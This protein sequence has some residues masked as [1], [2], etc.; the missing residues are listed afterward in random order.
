[1]KQKILIGLVV[2][3]VIAQFFR[4]DKSHPPVNP[5]I[6]FATVTNV[7]DDINA[8]MKN[9][10]YD[11][12][13]HEVTYPWYTNIAPVSWWIKGHIRNGAKRLNF[14]E[15]GNYTN[16]QQRHQ[17]EDCVEVLNDKRMPPKSYKFLHPEA[18]LSDDDRSKIV[19]WMESLEF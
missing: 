6:D 8:M 7:P 17:I 14:S 19:G 15:W 10:C 2:L 18:Q 13:S 11:C 16:K 5:K 4:I 1:M 12:H 3:L 9:A